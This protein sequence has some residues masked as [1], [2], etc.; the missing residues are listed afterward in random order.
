MTNRKIRGR[1]IK[2]DGKR[3]VRTLPNVHLME[4]ERGYDE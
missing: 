4:N 3:E 2:F 1:V